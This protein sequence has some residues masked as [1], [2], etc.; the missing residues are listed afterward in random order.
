MSADLLQA[1]F[2]GIVS[3]GLYNASGFLFLAE[4]GQPYDPVK[5]VRALIWGAVVG[6]FA[7][8]YGLPI[9]SADSGIH[10]FLGNLGIAG[11]MTA[12]VDKA[13]V[14]IA[15]WLLARR[16]LPK[17]PTPTAATLDETPSDPPA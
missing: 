9:P 7:G 17:P 12:L 15:R 2:F 6:A 8:Y 11:L 3:G 1:V 5:L 16:V 14:K 13:S 10:A 4:S